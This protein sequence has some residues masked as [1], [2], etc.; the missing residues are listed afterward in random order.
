MRSVP[1]W[2]GL[3]IRASSWAR[4][5]TLR[6]RS[7]NLSN[8]GGYLLSLTIGTNVYRPVGPERV[9]RVHCKGR[10]ATVPTLRGLAV[11]A[12]CAY[13]GISGECPCDVEPYYKKRGKPLNR[14]P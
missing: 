6:A 10:P 12:P 1:R 3:S 5:T 4:T 2:L 11:R 14:F 7:V 9:P 13:P 8:I